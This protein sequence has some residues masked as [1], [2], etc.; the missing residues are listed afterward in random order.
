MET[1]ES[2]ILLEKKIKDTGGISK[3]EKNKVS[4]FLKEKNIQ[5]NTWST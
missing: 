3:A 4:K 1:I 2:E 5:H